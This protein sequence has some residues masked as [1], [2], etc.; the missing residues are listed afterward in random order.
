M[1]KIIKKIY[2]ACLTAVPVCATFVLTNLTNST[3]CWIRGQ[4]EI[5]ESAKKYRKF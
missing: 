2:I 3:S 5:P 4:E 1:K